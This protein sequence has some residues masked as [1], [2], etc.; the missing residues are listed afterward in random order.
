MY[1]IIACDLDETL[2]RTDRTISKEDIESIKK[3]TQKGVKFVIATGRVCNIVQETLKELGLYDK[4]NELY[5]RGLNYDVCI[6][7]YIKSCLCL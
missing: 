6:H 4:A 2:I 7:V 1:E 3:A 5:K